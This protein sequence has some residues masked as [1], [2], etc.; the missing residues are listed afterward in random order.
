MIPFRSSYAHGQVIEAG[1]H[2][3]RLAVNPRARRVSL[4][5]DRAKGEIVATAP[6]VRK[7]SEA[8]AFAKERSDWIGGLLA[9][10]PERT[11]LE[12]GLVFDLFGQPCR[13]EAGE[14]RAR[15]LW[16]RDG[17]PA[18]IVAPDDAAFS[19]RAL[20]LVKREAERVLT[21]RTAYYCGLIEQSAPKVTIVDPR[22]RWGSCKQAIGSAPA[23]IR[24]SWRLALAP[25]EVADYVAAHEVA[26]LI[27]ANH[28]PRFWA[29]VHDL[30]GDH[31]P[32]RDWLK[33]HGAELQAF[34]RG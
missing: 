8:V 7:L 25:L 5:L 31:R 17:E 15:L 21:E 19:V 6:T 26:H 18:R 29:L 9:R 20:R 32:H 14:G 13:L 16:A 24:Y 23:S 27:E 1:G 3:V 33:A 11:P 2:A 22:G 34:G 10:Q 30:V 28:G 4:R 12:P